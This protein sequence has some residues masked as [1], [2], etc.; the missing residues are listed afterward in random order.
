MGCQVTRTMHSNETGQLLN[1]G[2]PLPKKQ[3]KA[4][5]KKIVLYVE[6]SYSE[7]FKTT[8][9]EMWLL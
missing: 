6:A 9:A 1:P 3:S 4:L 2:G 5:V 7:H 8:S